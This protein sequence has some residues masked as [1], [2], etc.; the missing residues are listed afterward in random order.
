[1]LK[2][3][4]VIV[5]ISGVALVA[6]WAAKAPQPT[7]RAS[8]AQVIAPET[9]AIWDVTNN[10]TDD[11]G[12]PDPSKISPADWAR[13]EAAGRQLADQARLLADVNNVTV[14]APGVKVQDEGVQGGSSAKQIQAYIDANRPAFAAY[15]RQLADAGDTVV[16]ASAAKDAAPLFAVA[17]ELDQRCESCHVQFWYPQQTPP[18]Q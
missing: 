6:G 4:G 7:V 12:D 17:S 10:A 9:Q 8:M 11:A 18:R 14:A 1:M 5:L 13:M 16:K 2:R 15:A 3:V